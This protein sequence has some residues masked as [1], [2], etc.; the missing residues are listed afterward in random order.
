MYPFI[1]LFNDLFTPVWS[2]ELRFYN[3]GYNLIRLYSFSC[4]DCISFGDWEL[5]Q[6]APAPA[7]GARKCTLHGGTVLRASRRSGRLPRQAPRSVMGQQR[8]GGPRVLDTQQ[9]TLGYSVVIETSFVFLSR[10]SMSEDYFGCSMN[11][12]VSHIHSLRKCLWK[13][14]SA[15]CLGVRVEHDGKED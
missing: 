4:L 1:N 7:R 15:T 6:L 5:F 3:L 8:L 12:I 13:P 10:N 11:S 2:Q 14:D 9:G